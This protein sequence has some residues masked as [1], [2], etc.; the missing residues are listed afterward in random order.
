[1]AIKL[2]SDE[3][4]PILT[5]HVQSWQ[6]S[7]KEHV[8]KLELIHPDRSW[9]MS[10]F[11]HITRIFQGQPQL[12]MSVDTEILEMIVDVNL[13]AEV[14]SVKEISKYCYDE[15]L[16]AVEHRWLQR[17]LLVKEQLPEICPFIVRS[18]VEKVETLNIE[19]EP[20]LASW[21]KTPKYYSL[22]KEFTF[23]N[24]DGV[25]YTIAMVRRCEHPYP[26]LKDSGLT[27]R[28]VE[29][30]LTVSLDS[31]IKLEGDVL[32]QRTLSHLLQYSMI[33]YHEP[34]P[35][36]TEVRQDVL[37]EY[38]G[39]IKPHLDPRMKDNQKGYF[40]APKPVTLERFHLIDPTVTYGVVSILQGYA[41]TDKADGERMLLY[42]DSNGGAYFIDNGLQVR[43]SG[44]RVSNPRLYQTLLDGEY[45]SYQKLKEGNNLFAVFDIYFREGK[46]VMHLPLI[47]GKN[48]ETRYEILKTIVNSDAW[49]VMAPLSSPHVTIK[50]KIQVAANGA[51]MFEACGNLLKNSKA[52][53]YE[54]DGL[55]FTPTELPV[56]GYYPNRPVKLSRSV[57]WDRVLKWKPAELNTIDFLI[58][59]VDDVVDRDGVRYGALQLYTG[60]NATQWEPIS[61]IQG[62][63][64]RYDK[65]YNQEYRQTNDYRARLFTPV[66]I[67]IHGI[68]TAL[69]PLDKSGALR[70]MDGEVIENEMVVEFSYDI[71]GEE[72]QS[73]VGQRWKALRV[74]EDKTR[75]FR[76]TN[77]ISGAANDYSVAINIWRTMHAPVTVDM[78]TGTMIVPPSEAPSLLEE[79]V[80]GSEEVYYARLV[81]REHS[82]SYH[83]LN[84]HNIGVKKMLYEKAKGGGQLLE[85]ACGKAGDLSRWREVGFS[86][87]L[88]VDLV[89]NN[90]DAP[91]D[92]SY[93]RLLKFR[94]SITITTNGQERTIYPNTVFVVGDVAKRIDNGEAAVDEESRHILNVVYGDSRRQLAPTDKYLRYIVGRANLR[95]G[96]AFDMV[97]CQFAVHY[98]W[99]DEATLRSFLKNVVSN[100]KVGGKFI[101]TTMDGTEVHK[102]IGSGEVAEGRKEDVV[103]WAIR[104]QY[105]TYQDGQRFGKQV[106]IY[107]EMTHKVIPEYLV[108]F[109]TFV[110]VAKSMGLRLVESELFS[111]TYNNLYEQISPDVQK[112]SRL[113][114]DILA[115]AQED[116]QRRF[117]FINRWYVFEKI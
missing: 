74:R 105:D 114:E 113:D 101:A 50:H 31:A 93:A 44:W 75:L 14:S 28:P 62:L 2:R 82:Y 1:M 25:Q 10:D 13:I 6:S 37:R 27:L 24:P 48:V 109:E 67:T 77:D 17:T 73:P 61:P 95:R 108:H 29:L 38:Y 91:A 57:R 76:R 5:Q 96:G 21:E 16:P 52:L 84:F 92:G 89:R 71:Q 7:T 8:W 18:Y 53:P 99:K 20:T 104:K 41:V 117:S 60:Y 112:R 69:V 45:V 80:L 54:I 94:H 42:I 103:V 49:G 98:M 39:L 4:L 11:E 106:D 36:T 111:R 34:I 55:I 115:L 85:L 70:T 63:R 46:S 83:M 87:V 15:C 56:F 58:K 40:L 35:V 88:G 116:V 51:A 32:I 23:K 90:I 43:S 59:R 72:T 65:E 78:L 110:D 26:L 68:E 79:R 12:T 81:P 3:L 97:S 33:L 86:F 64:L 30:I 19:Q 100:L 47:S 9:K 66:P 107:L 22:R 102:L